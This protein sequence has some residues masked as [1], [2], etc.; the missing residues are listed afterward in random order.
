MSA[1]E[2]EAEI[3][4]HIATVEAEPDEVVRRIEEAR[5]ELKA[6]EELLAN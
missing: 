1:E 6:K 4:R 2:F 5:A 3:R